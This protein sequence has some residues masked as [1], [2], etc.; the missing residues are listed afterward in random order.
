MKKTII[1]TGL[2]LAFGAVAYAAFAAFNDLP[3]FGP[4]FVSTLIAGFGGPVMIA[5]GLNMEPA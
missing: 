3:A 5:I 4:D 1:I 2:T